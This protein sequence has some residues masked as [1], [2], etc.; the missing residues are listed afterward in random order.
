M[1]RN[2]RLEVIQYAAAR[3]RGLSVL[4][5]LRAAGMD[6]KDVS[7]AAGMARRLLEKPER[8]KLY[9]KVFKE[10][11]GRS[12]SNLS[13]AWEAGTRWAL[14]LLEG[15][16]PGTNLDR[17]H[18]LGLIGRA[19]GAFTSKSEVTVRHVLPF[20]STLPGREVIEADMDTPAALPDGANGGEVVK[21]IEHR[22]DVSK[23]PRASTGGAPGECDALGR[24]D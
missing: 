10:E 4:D 9:D 18:A 20:R 3:S 17:L 21:V 7:S 15:D 8:Q 11:R 13:R 24:E 14:A 1:N 2:R 23:V 6:P 5:S 16:A 12:R 19:T 22:G